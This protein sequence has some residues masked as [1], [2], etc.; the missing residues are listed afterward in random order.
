MLLARAVG[1]D[2]DTAHVLPAHC[3][4]K[5]NA[6]VRI[7]EVLD[8]FLKAL[9]RLDFFHG[10]AEIPLVFRCVKYIYTLPGSVPAAGELPASHRRLCSPPSAG[11]FETD[12]LK[13]EINAVSCCNPHFSCV[14]CL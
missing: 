14:T 2:R 9:G 13:G 7:R 8:A 11:R 3:G 5:L 1:T 4:Q 10:E 12:F 6:N